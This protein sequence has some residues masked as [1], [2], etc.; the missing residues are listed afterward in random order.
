VPRL[1]LSVW[2]RCPC[3][4]L[5]YADPAGLCGM[6]NNCILCIVHS[7]AVTFRCGGKAANPETIPGCIWSNHRLSK[8]NL[9]ILSQKLR[10][11]GGNPGSQPGQPDTRTAGQKAADT[12]KA[13]AAAAGAAAPAPAAP[14]ATAPAAPAAG[15]SHLPLTL[16]VTESESGLAVH[17]ECETPAAELPLG[18]HPNLGW[19]LRSDLTPEGFTGHDSVRFS[20]ADATAADLVAAALAVSDLEAAI[21]ADR[22]ESADDTLPRT[23]SAICGHYLVNRIRLVGQDGTGSREVAR[24]QSY[25]ALTILTD[26]MLAKATEK[27][28]AA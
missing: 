4:W 6:C 10:Q 7:L 17:L 13:N 21:Q 12:R 18:W 8:S 5:A 26:S 25:R 14:A 3:P 28:A 22:L 20:L 1:G 2:T 19:T 27:R 24:G 11:S 9:A 23:V 16:V 15:T